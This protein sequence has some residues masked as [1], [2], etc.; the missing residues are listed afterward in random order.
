LTGWRLRPEAGIKIQRPLFGAA[1]GPL[2]GTGPA[3][4]VKLSLVLVLVFVAYALALLLSTKGFERGKR[5]TSG[6]LATVLPL[7]RCV[8]YCIA[9]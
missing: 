2:A 1:N 7:Y 6:S 8:V 4:G 9:D 3:N 5:P